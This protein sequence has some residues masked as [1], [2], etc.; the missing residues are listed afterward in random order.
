MPKLRTF[1]G[2]V[3][4]TTLSEAFPVFPSAAFDGFDYARIASPM[5]FPELALET[6]FQSGPLLTVEHGDV[7]VYVELLTEIIFHFG[8][9]L[10]SRA[11]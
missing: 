8:C 6:A 5:V 11:F 7:R 10:I 2:A 1:C 4:N 3:E 9:V